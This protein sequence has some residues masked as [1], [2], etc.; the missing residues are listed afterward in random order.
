MKKYMLIRAV[1]LVIVGLLWHA[2]PAT[3]A[4]TSTSSNIWQTKPYWQAI[5]ANEYR[6]PE[7]ADAVVLMQT[8]V[9]FSALP[10][11]ELRDTIGYETFWRW[12]HRSGRFTA[13]ELDAVRSTLTKNVLAG[14]GEQNTDSVFGRS[15]ALLFLKELATADLKTPFLTEESFA[16]LLALAC[17]SLAKERDLRGY[18]AAKGWAH[19]TAHAADLLRALARSPRLRPEQLPIMMNAIVGRARAETTAWAWGED[20]RLGAVLA[21]LAKRADMP[22]MLFEKWTASLLA[23]NTALWTGVFSVAQYRRVHAQSSLVTQMAALLTTS[24][25][26]PTSTEVSKLLAQTIVA[27]Q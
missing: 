27:L 10:D 4:T 19:Q 11:P 20:A 1:G 16:E 24:T 3:G 26:T 14:V 17:E 2:V 18:V 6:I 5:A 8:L 25:V 12:L 15:F 13:A 23:E 9:T 7:H 22:I 21:T